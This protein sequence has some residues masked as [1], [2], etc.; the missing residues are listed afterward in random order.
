MKD[1]KIYAV[2]DKLEKV[3]TRLAK[4]NGF[5]KKDRNKRIKKDKKHGKLNKKTGFFVLKKLKKQ[6]GAK[7]Y[8]R[9]NVSDN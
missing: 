4:I 9:H 1:N 3:A 2:L 8:K 7:L 5:I 6:K